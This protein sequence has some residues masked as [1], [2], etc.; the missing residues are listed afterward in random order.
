M[1]NYWHESIPIAETNRFTPLVNDYVSRQPH[2]AEWVNDFPSPDTMADAI[3]R[4][5]TQVVSRTVLVDVLRKQYALLPTH[6]AVHSNI[7][8]LLKENTFSV[9]T[10]HQPLLFTGPFYFIYKTVHSIALAASLSKQFPDKQ[11][12]PVF[13]LG[14]EDHD[15][16]EIGHCKLEGEHIVWETKQQGACGR[17]LTSDMQAVLHAYGKYWNEKVPSE[18]AWM[19][20]LR[21]A[22]NGKHTLA[23]ATRILLHYLFGA[24]GLVVLD[25]D[26]ADLKQLFV[27]VMEEELFD[28]SSEQ[29]LQPSL[30]ALEARYTLQAG[31]KKKKQVGWL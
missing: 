16:E 17:M 19:T 27:P 11:F 3:K 9:C 2:L 14:S 29:R 24:K 7:E 15:L 23:E 10:A 28:E 22:Y 21:E 26:D 8:A 4:K 25:A 18:K 12:V 30:N 5:Q 6:E 13:Y 31:L 20:M 1:I